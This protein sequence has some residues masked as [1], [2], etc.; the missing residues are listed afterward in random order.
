M[1]NNQAFVAI[2]KNISPITGADTKEEEEVDV[3]EQEANQ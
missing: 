2:L 3:E 1:K